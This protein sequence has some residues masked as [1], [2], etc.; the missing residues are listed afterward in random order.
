MAFCSLGATTLSCTSAVILAGGLSSRFG[1]DKGLLHLADRPLVSYVLDAVKNVVDQKIIVVSNR[2]QI[3]KYSAAVGDVAE[4]V[5]DKT[6][7]RSPLAG[8]IS[9]FE[10]A[11]GEYVVLL[12]CDTP[13]I[14]K[15]VLSLVKELCISRNGC[16]PRW[17]N[18]C[19]EP[20]QAAY[21]RKAVLD[22]S[23]AALGA[24]AMNF[25]ALV[26]RLR[27]VRY[28]ST[29]VLKQIDPELRTFFNINTLMDL[30]LAEKVLADRHSGKRG[31]PE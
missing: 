21:R 10:E 8:A 20:L 1:K 24:C 6:A 2:E 14:S 26:E 11:E 17:P 31:R 9:G 19:I 16:I 30:R 18:G 7:F 13:F 4:I 3:R 15:D 23:G 22:A 12:P 29:L 28:V 25:Q 27:C 5:S